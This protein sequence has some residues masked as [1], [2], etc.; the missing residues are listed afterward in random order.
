MQEARGNLWDEPCDLRVITTNGATRKD[1][2]AIMGRGCALEAKQRFPGIDLKLGRLIQQH[3]NRVMRLAKLTD[4]SV[5]ASYPVKHHWKEEA[6]PALIERSAHQ[7]VALANTFGQTNVLLPRPGCGSGRLSWGE[8]KP[9]LESILDERFT[10]ITYPK[11][12]L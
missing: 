5:L 9:L 11:D 6:D 7:L 4:G 1:G 2:A 10:V 12:K 8:V 3:G